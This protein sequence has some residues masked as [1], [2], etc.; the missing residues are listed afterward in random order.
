MQRNANYKGKLTARDNVDVAVHAESHD[1]GQEHCRRGRQHQ[2]GGMVHAMSTGYWDTW[3]GRSGRFRYRALRTR[4]LRLAGEPLQ[5][6]SPREKPQRN[7][8][9]ASGVEQLAEVSQGVLRGPVSLDLDFNSTSSQPP[10]VEK[11]AKRCLD[12]LGA[13]GTAG[14]MPGRLHLLYRDDVQVALLYARLYELPPGTPTSDG[15]TDV[16]ARPLRDV[17]DD[18]ELAG[19]LRHALP[20]Q[21][22]DSSSPFFQPN[23]PDPDWEPT[24]DLDLA[25][26][27]DQAQRRRSLNAWLHLKDQAEVQEALLAVTDSQIASL[28]C[29]APKRLL[30]WETVAPADDGLHARFED[31]DDQQSDNRTLILSSPIVIPLPSLPGARGERDGFLPRIR[32]QLLRWQARWPILDPLL[33]PLKVTF[34]VVPPLAVDKDL[35]N[36]VLEVLPLVHEVLRPDPKP[37]MASFTGL[38]DDV[39]ARHQES[40]DRLQRLN[41]HSVASYEIIRLRRHHD[42]PPGGLFRLAL[43][44]GSE[45]GSTWSRIAR[46]VDVN[47]ESLPD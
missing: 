34:L 2:L 16:T 43:G 19:N 26:N 46:Y 17:V 27:P 33:V 31:L 45:I 44:N 28:L 42:D 12:V 23:V 38:P 36:I 30:P 7:C 4:Y 25:E 8:D 41:R 1:T 22:D 14:G 3:P 32:K 6:K 11:L 40:R 24:F 10:G 47:I 18:L 37:W 5:K 9:F 15:H 29:L 35:D 20:L 39:R 21:D 13:P